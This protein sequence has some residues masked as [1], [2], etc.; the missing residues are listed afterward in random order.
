M[1]IYLVNITAM[2]IIMLNQSLTSYVPNFDVFILGTTGDA[3]TIW[4]EFHCIYTALMVN[5]RIDKLARGKVP[6]FHGSIV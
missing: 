4:M 6:K 3:C 5:E 2:R 1:E